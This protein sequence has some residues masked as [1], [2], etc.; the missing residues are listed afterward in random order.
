[1]RDPFPGAP[2]LDEDRPDRNE[3][4]LGD[5]IMES[6]AV[7]HVVGASMPASR[8]HRAELLR[9]ARRLAKAVGLEVRDPGAA[10]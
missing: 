10:N 8:P 2:P 1:M 3:R 5:A 4:E 6:I 7:M 9:V